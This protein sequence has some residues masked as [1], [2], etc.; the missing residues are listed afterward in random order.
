MR[1]RLAAELGIFTGDQAYIK[2][3][4]ECLQWI[5]NHLLDPQTGLIKDHL[6]GTTGQV[7][8]WLFTYN[9]GLYIG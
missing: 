3:A 8:D 2:Q 6:N 9:M 5:D 4:V 7:T 1:Y